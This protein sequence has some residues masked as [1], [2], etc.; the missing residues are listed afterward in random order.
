VIAVQENQTT[1]RVPPASLG[2]PAITVN[3]YLEAIGVL[4]AQR[5]G[6]HP[7]ALRPAIAALPQWNAD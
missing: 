6:I 1:M 2:I 7:G 5:A 3:S 4:V